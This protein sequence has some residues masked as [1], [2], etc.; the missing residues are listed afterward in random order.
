MVPKGHKQSAET[1]K[2]RRETMARKRAEREVENKK[3]Q[4]NIPDALYFFN[5]AMKLLSARIAGREPDD[6]ELFVMCGVRT[7]KGGLK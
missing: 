7:L 1:I 4:T 6:F 3:L 5:K 2:R